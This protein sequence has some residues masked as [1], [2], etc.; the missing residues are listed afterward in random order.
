MALYKH[1]LNDKLPIGKY[2]Y[3]VL[4]EVIDKHPQYVEWLRSNANNNFEMDNVSIN[5]LVD[6]LMESLLI[7]VNH[8]VSNK[9]KYKNKIY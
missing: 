8:C 2:K 3:K 7:H 6:K 1:N 5:Y 9:N 4:R